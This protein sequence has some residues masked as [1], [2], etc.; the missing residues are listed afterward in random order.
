MFTAEHAPRVVLG[1]RDGLCSAERVF[2]CSVAAT[3]SFFFDPRLLSLLG[4]TTAMS[5]LVLNALKK[6]PLL[7]VGQLF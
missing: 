5:V 4:T 6:L 7:F 3:K 2:L 1:E